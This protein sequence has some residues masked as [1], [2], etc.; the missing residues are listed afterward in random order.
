[1]KEINNNIQ[2]P[3]CSIE[4]VKLLHGKGFD[5][6]EN[7]TCGG[8]PECICEHTRSRPNYIYRPTHA[9]VIEWIRVNFGIHIYTPVKDNLTEY[10]GRYAYSEG[11]L[12]TTYERY[13]TPKEATEAVLLYVVQNIIP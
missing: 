7:C 10:F 13:E 4:L 5:V 9:L 2:E 11:I 6:K 8:F 12:N 1:M 3:I